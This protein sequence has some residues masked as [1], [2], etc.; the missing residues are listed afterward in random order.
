[1]AIFLNS[2]Q[3]KTTAAIICA[4]LL[5]VLINNALLHNF[6]LNAQ[7]QQL[8]QQLK[9]VATTA[10]VAIDV[11][12][13]KSIPLTHEGVQTPAYKLISG[14]LRQIK[15]N[16][17]KIAYVYILTK[18]SR[19]GVWQFLVDVDPVE[20]RGSG[21]TSFPGDKY[22]TK[23]FPEMVNG[24]DSPAADT[25]LGKDQWGVFLS[26]YAPIKDADGK[27]VAMLGI[28]MLASDIQAMQ[29]SIHA[30]AFLVL[31]I[32]ILLSFFVGM[33]LSR[34]ITK[35]VG[36]L[37]EGTRHIKLG[38]LSYRVKVKGQDE[39]AE[40]SASFNT[41]TQE[42]FEAKKKNTEYFYGVIQSMIRIVEAKDHYTRG[43]SERVAEYAV[44]I[45]DRMGFAADDLEMLQQVAVL[46]DIGKLG[47][48]DAVLNKPAK[49]NDEEWAQMS[50]HPVTGEDILRPV[51]L[52]DQML[53]IV[54]GHH[55][56]YDGK[57]YP[58]GLKADEVNMFTQIITVADAYDAMTSS[59]AYR[60][61][62][63]LKEEAM[64]ELQRNKGSQFNPHVVDML[65]RV[66]QEENS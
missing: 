33:L 8:R 42:L 1:M 66:L 4:L 16:D 61:T 51:L 38:D 45:A 43:H 65:C 63:L 23:N 28:D 44:K 54:R 59:R 31:L 9:L 20:K 55:E 47:I 48:Q 50:M 56:R 13:L 40:L 17:P 57:G 22:D 32:G 58:D 34:R 11:Q 35:R 52:D 15:D 49:L 25:K 30:R 6:A 14:K 21:I 19:P 53:A 37:V 26:G 36:Y 60:K 64:A 29:N 18:T 24:W 10:V 27:T 12:A 7:F 39:L 3:A 2:V 5:V 41:M 46:H 62:A